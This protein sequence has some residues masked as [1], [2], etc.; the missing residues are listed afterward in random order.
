MKNQVLDG[1]ELER[2]RGI[3]IKAKPVRMSYVSQDNKKY[4]LNLIDTPGHVDFTCEVSRSLL[5]CEGAVLVIDATQGIEAQ[6]LANTLL[7]KRSGL[8]I[9]PVIN[10]ID[11]YNADVNRVHEQIKNMLNLNIEP[12]LASAKTGSG[13]VEIINSIIRHI[14]PPNIF[15]NK[16]LSA[17]IFDSFYDSY[18]G[19]IIIVRIFD[20]RVHKGMKLRFI[21]S[22]VTHDVL[23]V[24]YM[25]I[26][27]VKS[28]E[29]VS[30]EVGY[31]IT[32]IKNIYDIKIGDT[33]TE[34]T[35]LTKNI[36][37]GYKEIKPLLYAGFY[38][39]NASD[40]N[41]LKTSLEKL[42]LSDSSLVY[43]SDISLALGIGFRCGFLGSL[44]LEI[45]R[46]RLKREFNIK[47]LVTIPNVIYKIN[48][49]NKL[50]VIDSPTKFPTNVDIKEVFEPYVEATIIC[51]SSCLGSILKLCQQKRGKQILIKYIS[52]ETIILKYN[53]P[54]AEIIIDFYDTLK[55]ISKGYASFDYEYISHQVG[56]L[57]KLEILLNSKIIDAFTI[58][59]HKDKAYSFA[60]YFTKKLKSIIPRHMIEIYIQAKTQGKIIARETIPAMR[61][62][63][64]AKCYG[65]DITRKRKLLEK[66]KEGKRKMRQ[67]G[68]IGI[69]SEVFLEILKMN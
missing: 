66:Q 14:P 51:P 12:V 28:K 19:V 29:L 1:M 58:I 11:L 21:R 67:F 39:D 45:I 40:Y 30:G 53:M 32:N 33:V 65:G 46:E 24:G 60:R 2:E 6:T 8:K 59:V 15:I 57:V 47:L 37:K 41:S 55:S 16:P 4:I 63:V 61:K 27:M 43:S 3:T 25:M 7:A 68:K 48:V 17:L 34:N 23:E 10:K 62:D 49:K 35:N 44:H 54:L 56:D 9:I 5:V 38:P 18:R 36:H 31:I 13:V 50:I 64:I 42:K 69:P 52:I 26:K 22:G 20:G